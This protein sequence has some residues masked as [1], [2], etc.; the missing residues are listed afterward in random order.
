MEKVSGRTLPEAVEKHIRKPLGMER[1]CYCAGQ[2]H[3]EWKIVT[4]SY[5]NEPEERMCR[6]RGIV[7]E[8]FRPHGAAGLRA[9]QTM[10]TAGIILEGSAVM[11]D[12]FRSCGRLPSGYVLSECAGKNLCGSAVGSGTF[13]RAWFPAGSDV[14]G[15]LRTYRIYGNRFLYLRRAWAGSSVVDEPPDLRGGRRASRSHGTAFRISSRGAFM[16]GG[17]VRGV[18]GYDSQG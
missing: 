8:G 18:C 16:C 11:P 15:W 13:Q 4:S 12:Y 9:R 7:F 1:L 5:G 17:K 14:S 6:E 3:P 2:K 10:G